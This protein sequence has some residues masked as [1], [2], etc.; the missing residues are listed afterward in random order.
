MDALLG[1]VLD[2]HGG[3][4]RWREPAPRSPPESP[5]AA[6]SGSSRDI[7]D[8]P[9]RAWSRR[10]CRTSGS[11]TATRRPGRSSCSTCAADR[12]TVTDRAGAVLEKLEHPRSTFAGYTPGDAVEPGPDR[13]LPRVRHLALPGR[14]LPV[15]LAGRR[16]ARGGAVDR[17]RRDVAGPAGHLPGSRSTPTT[18][19][20]STTTTTPVCC[21]GWTT[22]R[23]STAARRWPTTSANIRPSTASRSLAAAHPAP[24]R[25]RHAGHVLDPD[26][27]RPHGHRPAL[28]HGRIQ[29]WTFAGSPRSTCTGR[30]AHPGAGG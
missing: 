12:V 20:S 17:G 13:L 15:H 26:H 9:G 6:R 16:G 10:A 30:S 3:L 21:A 4:D 2:A 27:R 22:R 1:R 18:R 19:P 8:S 28:S 23:T 24:Q 11:A 5:T 25:R 29:A 14:A 7:R